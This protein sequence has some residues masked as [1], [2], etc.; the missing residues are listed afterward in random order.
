MSCNAAWSARRRFAAG[1]VVAALTADVGGASADE[2]PANHPRRSIKGAAFQLKQ[3]QVEQGNE[4]AARKYYREVVSRQMKL[5]TETT[6]ESSSIKALLT[7]FGYPNVNPS[8]LH[9]LSSD[10]LMGLS[11]SGDIL[12][13]RFFAPK[14]SDVEDKPVATPEGG[15]G[16]RKLV[17]FNAKTG[18]PA[19]TNGIQ[20]VYI[21]QNIFAATAAE[22]P[23]GGQNVSRF[24]QAIVIRKIP[25]NATA[26]KHATY[27]FTYGQLVKVDNQNKP[28]LLNGQFQDAG[29]LILSLAATFNEDDRDPETNSKPKEYFV[30]DSCVQCHGGIR[31]KAKVNYLDTD[32]WFDR[33]TPA[34]GL[35][36]AKFGQE[37]FTALAQ[38]PYGVL[39]DG[40]KDAT[41]AQFDNAFAVIRKLNEEIQAQNMDVGGGNNFHLGAVTKWLQLHA[42]DTKHIPPFQRGF[43][44]EIWNPASDNERKALYYLNRYCYRCHSSLKYNVFDRQAVRKNVA[45]GDIENRLL[46]ITQPEAWMPQDRIFPGFSINQGVPEAA[47]DLKEFL[48]L[49]N[50]LQ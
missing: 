47:G 40:G 33:V 12:A 6:I 41:T 42:T 10:Q 27:F 24:N 7:F 11:A 49:L 14:I 38:S 28:I 48:D 5:E 19:D 37:D 21:L 50:Q 15:F 45:N 34:Y 30:P 25:S 9:G 18:S 3:F 4:Q 46:N 43:G 17:R 8:D 13:T 35:N 23:F 2:L 36:E 44:A 22:D 39:Y 16:W 20:A 29:P 31:I 26:A 32:H 1:L